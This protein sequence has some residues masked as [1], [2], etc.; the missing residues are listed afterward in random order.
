MANEKKEDFL[1]T[2]KKVAGIAGLGAMT[3][4]I[5]AT[6]YNLA[7]KGRSTCGTSTNDADQLVDAISKLF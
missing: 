3:V 4:L 6:T 2:T 7:T 5:G 1:D